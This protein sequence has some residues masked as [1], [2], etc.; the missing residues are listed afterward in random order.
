MACTVTAINQ[1]KRYPGENEARWILQV[2]P[3]NPGAGGTGYVTGGEPMDLTDYFVSFC[4]G[5]ELM[6]ATTVAANGI[7]WSIRCTPTA[8]ISAV[9]VLLCAHY[10][11]DP[12]TA[13]GGGPPPL[14]EVANATNLSANVLTFEVTGY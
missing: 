5:G 9:N 2:T 7:K 10:C 3:S 14:D 8:A 12:A 1:G 11:T 4:Y 13:I 6:G